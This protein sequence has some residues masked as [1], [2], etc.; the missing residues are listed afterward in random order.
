MDLTLSEKLGLKLRPLFPVICW[1]KSRK[2]N[3]KFTLSTSILSSLTSRTHGLK[4]WPHSPVSMWIQIELCQVRIHQVIIWI[5]AHVFP[6][7]QTSISLMPKLLLHTL[8][9]PRTSSQW[10]FLPSVDPHPSQQFLAVATRDFQVLWVFPID[11]TGC[12]FDVGTV[13]VGFLANQ[14]VWQKMVSN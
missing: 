5:K 7:I 14:G 12:A 10:T 6:S 11:H 13:H 9:T 2:Y 1:G 8:N 3:P 4:P